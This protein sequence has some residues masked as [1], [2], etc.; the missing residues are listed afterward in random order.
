M[1]V[2]LDDVFEQDSDTASREIDGLAYVIDPVT[3]EL[4]SF[5]DVATRVWALLDG[6]RSVDDVVT[7]I[8]KRVR[9]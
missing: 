6:T 7:C 4:H 8:A 2:E 1:S 5:N 9:D 3:A